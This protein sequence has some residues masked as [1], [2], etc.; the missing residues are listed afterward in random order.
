MEQRA[1]GAALK[2]VTITHWWVQVRC[3]PLLMM[4]N[5]MTFLAG[6][7]KHMSTGALRGPA[8]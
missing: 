8:F 3:R 4:A 6:C 5:W 1:R 7:N 2:T